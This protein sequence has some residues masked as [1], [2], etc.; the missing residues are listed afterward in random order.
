M[1]VFFP[2][3]HLPLSPPLPHPFTPPHK[4]GLGVVTVL[5]TPSPGD[6]RETSPQITTVWD[7]S[8]GKEKEL[9]QSRE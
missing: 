2:R 8:K 9:G 1:I 7:P 3:F 6:L 4:S 5:L